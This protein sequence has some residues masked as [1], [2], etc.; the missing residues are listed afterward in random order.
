V[1]R[2]GAD[3]Q[4]VFGAGAGWAVGTGGAGAGVG[5]AGVPARQGAFD[6]PAVTPPDGLDGGAPR[7]APLGLPYVGAGCAGPG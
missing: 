5:E 6:G 1:E 3:C 7:K 4:R 2:T